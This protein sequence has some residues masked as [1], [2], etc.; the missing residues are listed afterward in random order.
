MDHPWSQGVWII[1][2]PV[3]LDTWPGVIEKGDCS[4]CLKDYGAVCP[5]KL[6]IAVIKSLAQLIRDTQIEQSQ[7]SSEE[8]CS[9]L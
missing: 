3:Y 9:K 5:L 2:V 7:Y 6:S 1:E 4:P 8:Q